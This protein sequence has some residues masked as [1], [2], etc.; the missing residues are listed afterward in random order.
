[1]LALVEMFSITANRGETSQRGE[2]VANPFVHVELMTK[3]LKKAK[4]FYGRLFDWKLEDAP[5]P[6]EYTMIRPGEGTGGGMIVVPDA[7]PNWLA[8]VGVDDVAASTKKAK[9]LGATIKKDKTEVAGMGW[10]S[11]I[12]DPTGAILALWQPQPRK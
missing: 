1:M 2:I 3:D 10:F 6:M 8:Y 9:D 5:A 4:E 11:I 12:E 7:P